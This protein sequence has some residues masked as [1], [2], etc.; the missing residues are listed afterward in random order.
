MQSFN[1]TDIR[2][3]TI[4]DNC[5]KGVEMPYTLQTVG[6]SQSLLGSFQTCRRKWLFEINR[7]RSPDTAR[8]TEYGSLVHEILDKI[9]TGFSTGKFK[10]G[11]LVDVIR[12]NNDKYK[13]PPVFRADEVELHKAKA[14]AVLEC[15]IN[16]YKKDFTEM[17]FEAV[18]ESFTVKFQDWILRG[19][20]D[21]RYRDKNNKPWHIE[22][23]NYSKINES[24]MMLVLTFDL[25]NLLYMLAD[26]IEY[27]RYLMGVKYNI[28]RN[29]EVRKVNTP[30]E[31]YNYV[32][33]NITKDPKYYFIRYEIPYTPGQLDAF[34]KE[35]YFKL[36]D[37]DD[38]INSP[39]NEQFLRCYKNEKGCSAPYAC[40]F[41]NACSTCSMRGYVQKPVLFEELVSETNNQ[42]NNQN[43][44]G[45]IKIAPIAKQ[46][47]A[48]PQRRAIKI[49]S[50]H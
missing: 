24:I 32:K 6:I 50:V 40:D 15:Y 17:R 14:Q 33:E 36:K 8:K 5:G 35:L 41:V 18:E 26:W 37:I 3:L 12:V 13:F 4:P 44:R 1:H 48:I 31:L 20:K 34:S 7:W 49:L 43:T 28:L 27:Q 16:W 29:P 38:I 46:Q 30:F 25:Q 47:S 9:Y 19:K 42:P 39:K 10:Y 22:H 45:A 2:S 23:K 21:G 11:D